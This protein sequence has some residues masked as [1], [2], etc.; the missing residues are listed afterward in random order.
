[1]A[2]KHCSATEPL[3]AAQE[4]D[5][6]KP[7]PCCGGEAYLHEHAVVW[8]SIECKQC[9]LRTKPTT[10]ILDGQ[11]KELIASWNCRPSRPISAEVEKATRHSIHCIARI[12]GLAKS[13]DK[14]ADYII[15]YAQECRKD[16]DLIVAALKEKV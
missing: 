8:V 1:V 7:C 12:E 16:I 3:P 5:E 10:L 2:G 14:Y 6:L 9:G 13:G 4:A 11:R 15:N